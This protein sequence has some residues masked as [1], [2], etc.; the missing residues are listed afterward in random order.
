MER[1]ASREA[2][3]RE[4]PDLAALSIS[5]GREV[6]VEDLDDDGWWAASKGGRIE[7]LGT[8]GEGA[9][10]A[11]TKCRL[12]GGKTVFALKII[13]TDPDPDMQKQIRRE[14]DFNQKIAAEHIC[15]YYGAFGDPSSGII[16]ISMEYCEGGSLD[17]IY[18]EVKNLGGRIG[19]KP[20]GKVAEGGLSGLTYLHSCKI[21][22]R[23]KQT[24]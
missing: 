6:D 20:L 22:H 8:L 13:T 4:L 10:G 3:E 1:G 5:L 7:E 14:L 23:G 15:K 2:R 24:H 18:R 11:V 16:S 17:A 9:G 12:K 21:L 19:E